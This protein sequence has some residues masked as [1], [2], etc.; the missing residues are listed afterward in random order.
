M[1]VAITQPNFLPWIG[2]F[3][4]LDTVDI[5][6]SYDNVQ[7]PNR[8]YINRNQL[9]VCDD[10]YGWI[11]VGI[12]KKTKKNFLNAISLNDSNWNKK[13]KF[14]IADYYR[15]AGHF[16]EIYKWLSEALTHKGRDDCLSHYNY[17]IIKRIC[18]D[19]GLSVKIIQAS[20]LGAPL[21]G[22]AQDKIIT[23]LKELGATEYFNFASGVEAGLYDP[24]VFTESG[25]AIYKQEYLH[26]QYPQIGNVFMS[27]LSIVDLIMNCGHDSLA[28]IR[29]G[30]NWIKLN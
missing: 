7:F 23:I 14:K 13:N 5:W 6:V 27:H 1:K 17:R 16:N 9:K 24:A 22:N 8:S 15:K 19:I 29:R 3:D 20:M 10:Q 4:L 26:P 18:H 2:Y 25:I 30:R 12:D 11:T 21:T 28:V